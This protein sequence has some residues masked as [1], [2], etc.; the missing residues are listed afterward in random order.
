M[1]IS[2]KQANRAD[3][4]GVTLVEVGKNKYQ[5]GDYFA[6][7]AGLALSICEK[8]ITTMKEYPWLTITQEDDGGWLVTSKED[9]ET[10][11]SEDDLDAIIA[12]ALEVYPNAPAGQEE[13]EEKES[14]GGIVPKK[15]RNEYKAR[16]DESRCSDWLCDEIDPYVTKTVPS[17]SGKGKDK[18][19]GD[20]ETTYILAEANGVTKKWP[21]LNKGQQTMNARNMI[22]NKVKHSRTLVIPAALTGGEAKTLTPPDSWLP[23][24]AAPA[25]P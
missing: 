15:Y 9:G 3:T 17:K 8:I 22:R 16:G 5:A 24:A 11:A 4:L 7:T 21:N 13:P 20:A 23:Q 1:T 2:K 12:E 18:R 14:S 6:S 19:I 10:F 25:T